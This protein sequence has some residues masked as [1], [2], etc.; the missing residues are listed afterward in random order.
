MYWLTGMLG[1]AF[2]VAPFIFGYSGNS[3][4]LWTSMILGGS[5]MLMSLVESA[6]DNKGIW[7]YWVTGLVGLGAVVAPFV[8]G[9]GNV[10]TAMWISVA[11]GL[12]LSLIAGS[13]LYYD[14]TSF[15]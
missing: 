5:V 12:L 15:L 14:R 11:I 3:V 4:A 6:E 8:L 10:A 7:E 9:F 13:K 2:V 1:L